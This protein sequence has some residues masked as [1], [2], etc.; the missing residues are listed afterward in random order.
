MAERYFQAL[1]E[2]DERQRE[3]ILLRRNAGCS[4]AEIAAELDLH[5][6]AQAR[7]LL[8]RALAALARQMDR[9][10]SR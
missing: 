7:T 3:V 5:G 10:P 9:D 6:E 2:L 4:F 1:H 8:S